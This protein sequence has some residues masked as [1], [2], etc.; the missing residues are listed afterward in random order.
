METTSKHLNPRLFS[1]GQ[2]ST[3]EHIWKTKL[4]IGHVRAP[5]PGGPWPEVRCG[6]RVP[7]NVLI[8]R[9]PHFPFRPNVLI[10][11]G[12]TWNLRPINTRRRRNGR[13]VPAVAH[14]TKHWGSRRSHT[15][16]LLCEKVTS[17]TQS[18]QKELIGCG[19]GPLE[20]HG[21]G[22]CFYK[23]HVAKGVL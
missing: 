14:A 23:C 9:R 12:V 2:G 21:R 15:N 7:P 8:T 16:W 3:N 18:L 22:G 5:L 1:Q 19:G 4:L 17:A 11:G 13:V 6:G 20:L 10:K